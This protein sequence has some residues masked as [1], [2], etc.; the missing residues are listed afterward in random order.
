[1][2]VRFILCKPGIAENIG[3]AARA[4]LSMGFDDLC[5]VKPCK[6]LTLGA[7]SMACGAVSLLEKARVFSSLSEAAEDIDLLIGTTAKIRRGRYQYYVPAK[8]KEL[9]RTKSN[10]IAK[11][12]IVFGAETAGLSTAELSL[13]HIVSSIPSGDQQPSL[14]LAQAV[15]IYS[16]ELSSFGS[17]MPRRCT[18]QLSLSTSQPVFQSKI[19]ELL[20]LL[21]VNP[22]K[23]V[24]RRILERISSFSDEDMRMAHYLRKKVLAKILGPVRGR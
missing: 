7:R 16:Y 13:C 20:D 23:P 21:Q 2:E 11:V 15:M 12:A 14:N 6:H 19:Q 18:R 10:S 5:L 8:L 4:L 17:A 24:Y 22:R 1:M 9:L 3:A